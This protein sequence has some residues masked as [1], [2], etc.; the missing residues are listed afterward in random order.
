MGFYLN[1]EAVAKLCYI[2]K[3]GQLVENRV[4]LLNLPHTDKCFSDGSRIE[5]VLIKDDYCYFLV[6]EEFEINYI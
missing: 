2:S 5:G 1:P 6:G 4:N 3:F